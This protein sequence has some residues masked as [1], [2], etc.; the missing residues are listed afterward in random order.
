LRDELG[1]EPGPALSSLHR[2]ILS[3]DPELAAAAGPPQPLESRIR[4]GWLLLA[5]GVAVVGAVLAGAE[6]LGRTGNAEAV[7]VADDSVAVV[8]PSSDRVVADIPVGG[9]PGPLAADDKFVYVC[10]IGDATVTRIFLGTRKRWD[11]DAFSRATDLLAGD[12]HL[13]AANGGAPGHT[14]PGVPPGTI[15]DYGPGPTWKTIRV[16]PSMIGGEEQTTIAAD[17]DGYAIWAGNENTETVRQI[18]ASLGTTLLTIHGVAPAG[19]AAVGNSSAGDSVWVSDPSRNLVA[20]IDER[21][22]RIVARIHV[23]DGPTRLAA[24]DH[25]VWVVTRGKKQ[26]VW[27][28]DPRT[29]KPVTRIPLP[30]TPWRVA[31]G[32]GAVWVTAYRVIDRRSGAGAGAEV[33]RIDPHTNRIVARIP[34]GAR[35]AD[36]VIVSHGLV[37]V[38]VPPSQ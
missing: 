15:L 14:P 1:I 24:D 12:G 32:A 9:Y 18:D 27:R 33:I 22:R 21:A 38:A 13:W 31:V 17:G 7:A 28:I 5:A 29:N 36:G 8:D 4:R 25:A 34:L 30:L 37:W 20:R 16:G 6:T 23:P 26:A 2:A 19:L 3:H 35:V 10:N 11:T